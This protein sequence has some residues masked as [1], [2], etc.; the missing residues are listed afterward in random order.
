MIAVGRVE[1][2]LITKL[3]SI[4]DVVQSLPVLAALRRRFP[5]AYIGWAVKPAA[6][7]VLTGSPHL[8]ETLIVG[9][10]KGDAPGVCSV[11]PLTAPIRLARALRTRQFDLALDMQGLLKSAL[12]AFLSG[13]RERIGFRNHQEGAFL[14]NNRPVVPD[15]RDVHA[16]EAYLGFAEAL[17]AP[18][19][20]LDF[21]IATTAADRRAADE[22]LED[23]GD[24]V[25]LVPGARWLSKRWPAA[26][27]A[28]VATAL[29]SELG[30]TAAVVGG[31]EDRALAAEI[32]ASAHTPIL[33][34]TGRTTLKQLTEVFRRCRMVVSNETGPMYIAAAVGTP[35][36][37][38]FG[39]TDPLRLGPYGDGHAKVGADVACAPCRRRRCQPLR[40][41]EAVSVE[42]VMAAARAVLAGAVAETGRA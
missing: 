9:G 23:R 2:V 4:G 8:S 6:A 17:G 11:P 1:S 19:E 38:I 25:A 21:T 27:F 18:A 28:A 16:V 22:L 12:V 37:A 3:S 30:L 14:L 15:R 10:G 24:L 35:T 31:P 36:L 13:A 5:K 34:L 26:R 41:M 33:D 39:P 29:A 40:C 20:P 7:A 32:G 42:Q